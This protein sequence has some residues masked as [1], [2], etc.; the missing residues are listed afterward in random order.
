M[1]SLFYEVP[2]MSIKMY[3]RNP[4][5]SCFPRRWISMCGLW[6]VQLVREVVALA[7]GLSCC[8]FASGSLPFLPVLAKARKRPLLR[9]QPSACTC[10]RLSNRYPEDVRHVEGDKGPS[11]FMAI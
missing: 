2:L 4:K 8:R 10:C 11:S 3:M 6:L 5:S 7:D 9:R 1:L